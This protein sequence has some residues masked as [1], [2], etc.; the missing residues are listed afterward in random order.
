MTRAE[1]LQAA[2]VVAQ[3]EGDYF[4]ALRDIQ[5]AEDALWL[6]IDRTGQS[7]LWDSELAPA[8]QPELEVMNLSEEQARALAYQKRPDLKAEE[9]RRDQA[10]LSRRVAVNGLL[11]QLDFIGELGFN[12]LGGEVSRAL[13]STGTL[14]FEDWVIGLELS[15]PLQN[16]AA[17]HRLRQAELSLE[18]S[19]TSIEALR[20][21]ILFEVRNTLRSLQNALD[22]LASRNAEL[23]QRVVELQDEQRRYEVG[24]STTEIL[25]R[26]QDDAAT[27]AIN[28]LSARVDYSKA[29]IDL[30]RVMGDLLD[31]HGVVIEPA[32][33]SPKR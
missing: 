5:D 31:R 26:F 20:L 18:Q 9:Y 25:L 17:R 14:D 33:R 2:S 21:R 12:G 19:E 16:R 7:R 28:A 23:Q 4:T 6:R 13:D 27:A 11:P 29:L 8:D 3:R 22:L 15:H 32:P 1:E 30:D 10:D 24:L